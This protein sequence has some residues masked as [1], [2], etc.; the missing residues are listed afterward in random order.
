MVGLSAV[1]AHPVRVGEQDPLAWRNHGPS[2][3]PI[4]PTLRTHKGAGLFGTQQSRTSGPAPQYVHARAAVRF[5]DAEDSTGHVVEFKDI[6]NL[7]K[8]AEGDGK[9]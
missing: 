1:P 3:P 6:Y 5:L 2:S 7:V 4:L 8:K 9:A